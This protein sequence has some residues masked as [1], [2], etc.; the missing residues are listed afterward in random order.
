MI[1]QSCK[2]RNSSLPLAS[3]PV[4][5]LALLGWFSVIHCVGVKDLPFF[6][7]YADEAKDADVPWQSSPALFPNHWALLCIMVPC[8]SLPLMGPPPDGDEDGP[9]DQLAPRAEAKPVLSPCTSVSH[10]YKR[11]ASHAS[12][13]SSSPLVGVQACDVGA[14]H[15][16]RRPAGSG[17]DKMPDGDGVSCWRA[18]GGAAFPADAVMVSVAR[19]PSNW[20]WPPQ[21]PKPPA[22]GEWE[23]GRVEPGLG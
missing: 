22:A 21:I 2:A 18:Q 16:R 23:M 3:L 7:F 9:G 8:P 19:F 14:A 4:I 10:G 1:P 17:D 11:G 15:A 12:S 5:N 20:E 13:Q 6:F